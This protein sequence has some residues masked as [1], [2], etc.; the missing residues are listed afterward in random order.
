Q[1]CPQAEYT[2]IAFEVGTVPMQ[3]VIGALRQDQWFE[4]QPSAP[5]ADRAA[6]RRRMRD[7]FYTDTA[8][9]K[10]QVVDQGLDVAGAALRGLAGP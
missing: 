6:A 9:W 5:A 2:G 10:H 8:Q 1:E 7:T 3:E 4:N